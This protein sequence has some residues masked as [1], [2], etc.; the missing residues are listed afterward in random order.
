M[1]DFLLFKWE[2]NN[3][4][5]D[6]KCGTCKTVLSSPRAKKTCFGVHEEVCPKYHK[7][8]FYLGTFTIS[9]NAFLLIRFLGNSHKCDA[10][11]KSLML[12]IKR[13][14]EIA[15]LAQD[16]LHLDF[17]REGNSLF[18][19]RKRKARKNDGLR[20]SKIENSFISESGYS[21]G[22]EDTGSVCDDNDNRDGQI[23]GS[24]ESKECLEFKKTHKAARKMIR[25]Q[26][27]FQV[28]TAEELQWIQDALHPARDIL[29]DKN[30]NLESNG[31]FNNAT[32]DSNIAFNAH[33]AVNPHISQHSSF[34]SAKKKLEEKN[35][36]VST[37]RSRTTF[38]D[39]EMSAILRRLCISTGAASN[40]TK[41]RTS[42]LARL[43]DT[44]EKDLR[45]VENEDRETMARMAGYWRYVNR[46]TYNAMVRNNLLWDWAT[47]AKL[48][49]IEEEAESELESTENDAQRSP[50]CS[51]SDTY[52]GTPQ[53][54]SW[55]DDFDC[56]SKDPLNLAH[57]PAGGLEQRRG[58]M[59]DNSAIISGE[60]DPKSDIVEQ[61]AASV[62]TAAIATVK[63]GN[64]SP[65]AGVK[66]TRCL[67]RRRSTS[68]P[69]PRRKLPSPPGLRS[70][71]RRSPLKQGSG[72][73][74]RRHKYIPLGISH[75]TS[76]KLPPANFRSS[77]RQKKTP[78]RKPDPSKPQND[79][80]I[81]AAIHADN[82]SAPF[83]DPNKLSSSHPQKKI[84]T[85]R[86]PDPQNDDTIRAGMIHNDSDSTPP[87]TPFHDPH[88][89]FSLLL[90]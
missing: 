33:I 42:R 71:G 28:T 69:S 65:W 37:P 84:N 68:P 76:T 7:T 61:S 38:D 86:R 60:M 48:D 45:C 51:E 15:S 1:S 78:V 83:N 62:R 59:L 32:I 66:D 81:R 79:N 5:L 21:E 74:T 39:S 87:A 85:P 80:T 10:C 63:K 27:R 55:D 57:M 49:E 35:C 70:P 73:S 53:V 22:W 52:I 40:H 2:S 31:L 44:I 11:R 17:A 34:H 46:R 26:G 4:G 14:R 24:T 67:P 43:R 19:D 54:E 75:N 12:H 90:L 23:S 30:G 13:H 82:V 72:S 18:L 50:G 77:R 25:H 8:L 89:R 29:S 16:I 36:S 41:D 9:Y 88:N 6:H 58:Q 56:D 47:G 3:R 20:F 64:K